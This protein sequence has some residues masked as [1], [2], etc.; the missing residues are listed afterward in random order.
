M[1]KIFATAALVFIAAS[2]VFGQPSGKGPAVQPAFVVKTQEITKADFTLTLHYVGTIKAKDEAQ[3]FSKVPGKLIEYRVNEGDAVAKDA[4]I[5]TLDRDETG[6]T[7]EPAQVTAPMEGVIGRILLDKGQSVESGRTAVAVVVNMDEMIVRLAIPEQDVP[8]MKRGLEAVLRVDSYP[9]EEFKGR[10]T[11]VAEMVDPA[12]R[13]LP[14]E[15]TIPNGD[16]RLKSG[17]FARITVIA[18]QLADVLVVSQDAIVQELGER[19]VFV[20]KDGVANKAKVSLGR[21]D[22]EKIELIDGAR[23]GEEAIVFGHQGLRDGMRVTVNNNE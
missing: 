10:I 20:V 9:S 5:A 23:A 15:I 7:F 14:I 4:I 3:V 1:K 19:F 6:L 8:S 13:T 12:T 16:H 17:M 11:R 22:N 2:C 21:R 18:A